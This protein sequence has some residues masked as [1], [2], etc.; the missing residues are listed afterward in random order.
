M[1]RMIPLLI[2]LMFLCGCASQETVKE[3]NTWG[4]TFTVDTQAQTLYDGTY[5]YSYTQSGS[6]VQI[7]Y[8]DGSCYHASTDAVGIASWNDDYDSSPFS[9]YAAGHHLVSAVVEATKE[10]RIPTYNIVMGSLL[11]VMGIV[12]VLW[13]GLGIKLQYAIW[14]RDAEPTDFALAF[15][16]VV[17]VICV[18][19]GIVAFFL[20]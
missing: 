12:T 2:C 5:T 3:V 6:N 7:T 20:W 14:V 15:G 10:K 9:K 11:I 19:A 1:K 17:G 4:H 18:I 8:P 16:R 13:P